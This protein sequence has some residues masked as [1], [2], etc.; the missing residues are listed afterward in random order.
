ME[1]GHSRTKGPLRDPRHSQVLAHHS[2]Q[3]RNLEQGPVPNPVLVQVLSPALVQHN[4]HSVRVRN[5]HNDPAQ[6]RV[7]QV[8]SFNAITRTE[9]EVLRIIRI[10]NGA[11]LLLLLL[12][13]QV[14]QLLPE[15][16]GDEEDKARRK[17]EPFLKERFLFI[18]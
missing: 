16:W 7:H 17:K 10:I 2:D 12:L 6:G 9:T 15:A 11:D 5:H 18:L 3:V 8:I 1:T 14:A 4:H 13:L